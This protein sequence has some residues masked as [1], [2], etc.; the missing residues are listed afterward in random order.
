MGLSYNLI[1]IDDKKNEITQQ[2]FFKRVNSTGQ[3]KFAKV[4]FEFLY[5]ETHLASESKWGISVLG[6]LF[7]I[8]DENHVI[9]ESIFSNYKAD[10]PILQLELSSSVGITIM[11]YWENGKLIRK[12][13]EGNNE[14]I[15]MYKEMKEQ[16]PKNVYENLIKGD[17]DFGTNQWFEKK[18]KDHDT[19]IKSI[20]GKY[21]KEVTNI[22]DLKWKLIEE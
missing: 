10:F 12:R 2:G 5:N 17:E 3:I 4:D 14:F 18:G 9:T 13:S 19:I 1:F 21:D 20:L 8:A 11:S 15:E 7:I 6:N 22:F 16:I